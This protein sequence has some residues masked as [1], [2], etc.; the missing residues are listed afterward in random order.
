MS[1][2]PRLLVGMSGASGAIYGVRLLEILRR[3]PIESHLVMI[4]AAALTLAHETDHKV[5]DVC[6]LADAHYSNRAIDAAPASG[7]F[8]TTGMIVAPCSIRALSAI[9]TGVTNDLLTRAADVV[10]KQRR[11]L[12][13]LV[14]ETPLHAGHLRSMATVTEIGAIVAPPVPAFYTRPQTIDD[15]VDHTVGRLLDLFGFEAG[16]VKRWSGPAASASVRPMPRRR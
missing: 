7:S 6:E 13:L 3:L 16:H 8:E 14:R 1:A 9:A 12:V 2:H 5:A 11:R 10:L 4:P 15:I